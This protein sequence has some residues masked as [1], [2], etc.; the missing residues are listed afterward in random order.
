M[1]YQAPRGTVDILP[2]D[3][4]YWDR[5]KAAAR[6][7]TQQFGYRQIDTPTF[8]DAGLF[9]RGVGEGTDIQKTF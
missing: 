3:Q 8:E 2:E 9:V 7:V 4:V 1:Q 6:V 5:V